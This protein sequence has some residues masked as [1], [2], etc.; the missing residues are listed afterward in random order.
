MQADAVPGSADVGDGATR[1][2]F[3]LELLAGMEQPSNL[4]QIEARA[5]LSKS[6]TY[7]ALRSLQDA[8][9]VDHVGRKGYRLGTRSFA[10]ASLFISRDSVIRTSRPILAW[11]VQISNE[12]VSVAMRSGD[13]RVVVFGL[14]PP[15]EPRDM[16]PI[17][18]RTPLTSGCAGTSILAFLSEPQ[19]SQIVA[20][21]PTRGECAS[22]E[23]LATIRELGYAMSFGANHV[24]LNGIAAPLLSPL[25]G[26]PLGSLSISGSAERLDETSLSSLSGA[27]K[28]ATT[29]LS[30]LIAKRLGPMSSEGWPSL[31]ASRS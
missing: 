1:A 29:E 26:D 14:H 18:E 17:G 21:W 12:T 3:V 25:S 30:P 5:R 6:N 9:F 20:R 16:P 2:L 24:D 23:H 15:R 13:H 19:V 11:L 27:L 10:L 31:D 4:A 7:R 22:P 8:G 28:K